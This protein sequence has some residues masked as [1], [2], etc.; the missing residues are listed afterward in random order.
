MAQY[1]VGHSWAQAD[2]ETLLTD[3][4]TIV[5]DSFAI[6]V[7]GR[8]IFQGRDEVQLTFYQPLRA[9]SGTTTVTLPT[10]S[11]CGEQLRTTLH[12]RNDRLDPDWV[13]SCASSARIARHRGR[14]PNSI[15]P[16]PSPINAS[17]TRRPGFRRTSSA[18]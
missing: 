18:A 6:S 11:R 2:E 10:R 9:L 17:T 3:F 15:S 13:A 8:D 7:T 4:S 14:E 16:G 1:L 12:V 5:T